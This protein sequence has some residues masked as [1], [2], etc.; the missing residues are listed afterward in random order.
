MTLGPA[1]TQSA[2]VRRFKEEHFY[3]IYGRSSSVKHTHDANQPTP[4]YVYQ[5]YQSYDSK[6]ET[7]GE[8]QFLNLTISPFLI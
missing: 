3:D 4:Q 6:G 1:V 7:A 8:G 2:I 5:S